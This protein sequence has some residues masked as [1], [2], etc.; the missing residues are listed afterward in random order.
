MGYI[1]LADLFCLV[2]NPTKSRSLWSSP[3]AC[4]A[5]QPCCPAL[6]SGG[7]TAAPPVSMAPVG[8]Q[9]VSAA[10]LL[11]PC[12]RDEA[13]VHLGLCPKPMLMI[14][15][16]QVCMLKINGFFACEFWI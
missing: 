5:V 13:V 3:K 15:L 16:A 11:V 8:L 1:F 9:L 4:A 14:K 6:C 7:P 10:L 2:W 12:T